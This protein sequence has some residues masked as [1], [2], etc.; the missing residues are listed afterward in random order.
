MIFNRIKAPP[1]MRILEEVLNQQSCNPQTFI[2]KL[3]H[4]ILYVR[5]VYL[6]DSWRYKANS[7]GGKYLAI[8]CGK[9]SREI[10]LYIFRIY[11]LL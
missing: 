4:I 2:L 1:E 5:I 9:F 6:L 10:G 7:R 11:L 8:I 3:S